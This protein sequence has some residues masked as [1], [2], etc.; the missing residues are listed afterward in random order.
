ML[1][2]QANQS[3]T[4]PPSVDLTMSMSMAGHSSATELQ[5]HPPAKKTSGLGAGDMAQS[6]RGLN[7]LAERF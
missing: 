2:S 6:E 5:P 4:L 3:R 1:E 7:A